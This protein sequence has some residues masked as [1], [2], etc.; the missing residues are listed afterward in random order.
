MV[1]IIHNRTTEVEPYLRQ[2]AVRSADAAATLAAMLHAQ[3]ETDEARRWEEHAELRSAADRVHEQGLTACRQGDDDTAEACWREAA[4][5]GHGVAAFNLMS[6]LTRRESEE[7]LEALAEVGADDSAWH[8]AEGA[9]TFLAA[10][11]RH[12]AA[13]QWYRRAIE[14]A[15]AADGRSVA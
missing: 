10:A 6:L 1:L 4:A 14:L 15:R 2:A 13:L 11:G 12:D 9:A 3:G 5:A 7:N 8:A